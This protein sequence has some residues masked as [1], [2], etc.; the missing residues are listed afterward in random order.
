[1]PPSAMSICLNGPTQASKLD[2]IIKPGDILICKPEAASAFQIPS[3]AGRFGHAVLTIAVPRCIQR[4]SQEG[5]FLSEVWPDSEDELW[6][7]SIMEST[8]HDQGLHEGKLLIHVD[9]A[10]GKL[11][12]VAEVVKDSN[13]VLLRDMVGSLSTQVFQS[14]AAIREQLNPHLLA[15]VLADMRCEQ[16]AN[17]SWGTAVKAALRPANVNASD[18][19]Q[20]QKSWSK[21]PIC[22]SVPITFWQRFLSKLADYSTSQGQPVGAMDLIRQ[23]MP[24]K[25]NRSLPTE[26]ANAL[27]SAGWTCVKQV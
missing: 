13:G 20:V 16:Q 15:Q 7:V 26:L 19:T 8:R 2:T 25:A 6:A 21:R 10:T 14:P 9:R 24:V 4:A 23:W 3:V 17:W 12:V 5:A 11:K 1:M 27:Q 18:L 22:T